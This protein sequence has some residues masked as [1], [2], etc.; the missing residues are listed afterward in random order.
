M[1][2]CWPIACTQC[3]LWPVGGFKIH[4]QYLRVGI[5]NQIRIS[6]FLWSIRKYGNTDQC[7]HKAAPSAEQ[8]GGCKEQFVTV[9]TPLCHLHTLGRVSVT[10]SLLAVL[11]VA[12]IGARDFRFTTIITNA[13]SAHC[14]PGTIPN[15]FASSDSQQPCDL[16]P[17]R[18]VSRMKTRAEKGLVACSQ[19]HS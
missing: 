13:D 8:S 1:I 14:G 6:G 10:R 19:S 17:C 5:F 7:C 16:G 18:S 11:G 9:P 3:F 12:G 2:R 15:A 4:W